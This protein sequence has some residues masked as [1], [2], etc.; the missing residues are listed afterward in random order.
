MRIL[1]ESADELTIFCSSLGERITIVFF[2]V[3]FSPISYILGIIMAKEGGLPERLDQ[4]PNLIGPMIFL[5]IFCVLPPAVLLI[6][7]VNA[8][9]TVYEFRGSERRLI[10]RDRRGEEK[11]PFD[12][13]IRAEVFNRNSPSDDSY[14]YELRLVLRCG[15]PLSVSKISN[16]WSREK[17]ELAE[18]INRFL[19][20]HR[21]ERDEAEIEVC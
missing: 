15:R 11:T 4:V 20:A 9:D 2:L 17:L 6:G 16:S 1:R 14:A 13:I 3:I 7:L 8:R 10:V 18:R 21:G 5:L 12:D 19:E